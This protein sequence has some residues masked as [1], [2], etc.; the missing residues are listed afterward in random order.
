LTWVAA[1]GAPPQAAAS[2]AR[3][4]ATQIPNHVTLTDQA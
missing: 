3:G 4:A 1:L 2:T